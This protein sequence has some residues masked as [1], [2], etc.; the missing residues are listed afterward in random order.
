MPTGQPLTPAQRQEIIDLRQPPHNCS[1]KQIVA[2]TKRPY[3]TVAG[4]C[5]DAALQ[6]QPGQAINI[7]FDPSNLF[8]VGPTELSQADL[9]YMLALSALPDG[10]AF[11]IGPY[12]ITTRDGIYVRDDGQ[13]CPPNNSGT[14][15]W[16]KP[17]GTE[18]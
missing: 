9:S 17:K 12:H 1:Y 3:N 2:R 14:L 5:R 15:K 6:H 4:V 13:H 7:I 8:N 11:T 16:H 10:F 18:T